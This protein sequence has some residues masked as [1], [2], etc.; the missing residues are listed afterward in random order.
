MQAIFYQQK[1][2]LLSHYN[3]LSYSGVEGVKAPLVGKEWLTSEGSLQPFYRCVV[4]I[5][6][7]LSC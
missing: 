1:Q 4:F 3:C 6:N 5:V 7:Y 2:K